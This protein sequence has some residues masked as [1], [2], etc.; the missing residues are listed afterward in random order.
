MDR[1]TS[2]IA[3]YVGKLGIKISSISRGTGVPDGILRRSLS[4]KERDLRA[5]EFLAICNFLGKSPFDF[6]QHPSSGRTEEAS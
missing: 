4:A 2:C 6:Y 3:E 1:A 5:D